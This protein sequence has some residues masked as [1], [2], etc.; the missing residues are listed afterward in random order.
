MTGNSVAAVTAR[1][2]RDHMLGQTTIQLAELHR[3]E[4]L[5]DAASHRIA[6]TRTTHS[7]ITTTLFGALSRRR[8]VEDDLD[9][10]V[11]AAACCV[12]A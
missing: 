8:R 2:Y 9:V 3:A 5:A 7:A 11:A 10:D 1:P 4:L 12:A 6:R